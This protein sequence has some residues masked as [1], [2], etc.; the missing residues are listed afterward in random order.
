MGRASFAS[1]PYSAGSFYFA[2]GLWAIS[3]AIV[4]AILIF[5]A[6]HLHADGFKLPYAFVVVSGLQSRQLF[7]Y[8]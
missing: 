2:R 1:S 6:I 3:T 8:V 4:T 7:T 5:F